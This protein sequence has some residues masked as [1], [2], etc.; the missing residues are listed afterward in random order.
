M[1]RITLFIILGICSI[2]SGLTYQEYNPNDDRFKILALKKAQER[3][4]VSESDYKNYKELFEKGLIS[5]REFE[6]VKLQYNNDKLN[7]QQY[8]LS[9]VFDKPHLSILKAE[10]YQNERGET[11]V[12]MEL[13]NSTDSN[14]EME[15]EIIDSA[16]LK[17]LSLNS[18]HDVY[19]SLSDDSGNIISQPY[20]QHISELASNKTTKITFQLLK[21]DEAV[22]VS[23]NYGD[24]YDTKRIWLKRRGTEN[25]INLT[26][27]MY[28]QEVEFGFK[29]SYNISLEYY[30]ER[31][32]KC[33]FKVEGLP[34]GIE[35]HFINPTNGASISSAVFSNLTPSQQYQLSIIIP[36]KPD[37]TIEIGKTINFKTIITDESNQVISEL[38]LELTPSG[39]TLLELSLDNM[40]FSVSQKDTL[41]IY[42]I[43]LKNSGQVSIRN[44]SL[45]LSLPSG[46]ET[47]LIPEK[48]TFLEAGK[49]QS[50]RLKVIPDKRVLKGLYQV[51]LSAKGQNMSRA[52]STTN[53]ELRVEVSK[54]ANPWMTLLLVLAVVLIITGV[55][56]SVTK[57][58]KS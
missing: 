46:W 2:L 35:G 36:E 4:T 9:V 28:S 19:I 24:K 47:K 1:K 15:K 14:I 22:T 41:E 23:A 58:S 31:R 6:D 11:F 16:E 32:M 13:R 53:K 56:Y 52:I 49:E 55:I 38:P 7:F 27:N 29:A 5:E 45:D 43:K 48:I 33:L 39:R 34:K 17:G 40:Y 8:L 37:E 20:E 30:G 21:D 12:D 3:L 18:I 50:L 51:T 44:I 25:V 42:P 54:R 57:L 10:K 26:P